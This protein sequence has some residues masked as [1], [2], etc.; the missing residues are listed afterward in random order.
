[1]VMLFVTDAAVEPDQLDPIAFDPIDSADVR[2]VGA[3]HF[4]MLANVFEA[5]HGLQ[6][7]F[8]LSPQR[9]AHGIGCTPRRPITLVWSTSHRRARVEGRGK[10]A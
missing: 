7:S 10:H 9:F 3:D 5:A 4:H 8:A 1:V 2:A 6:A